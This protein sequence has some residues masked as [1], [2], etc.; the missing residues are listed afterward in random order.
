MAY[1]KII[2][3]INAETEISANVIKLA[4][5]YSYG[6]A[7]EL[8]IYN[9]SKDE[10]TREEF[11]SMA[12]E[13]S[14]EIDI[15]FSIGCYVERLEDIKKAIYTGARAVIIRYSIFENKNLLKE[16][17][18]RFGSEKIMVELDMIDCIGE[19]GE[20]MCNFIEEALV[21]TILLKHVIVSE[22]SKKRIENGRCP[23]IIRDSLVR[24]DIRTLL[25][26][27][28][29]IGLSTNFF[30]NKDI[31]KAKYALKE[32]NIEVNTFESLL[33]FSE[34]K[35]NA[36][37]LIPVVV[38][39]YRTDEVL[40]LAYMNE[41]AYNKTIVS[42]RMTYYSRSRDTLWLKGE[43]SGHYQY[44]KEL[45][46]DCDKDTIL[47]K[48]L[49]IGPAC[50]TGSHN[51]FIHDLVKKEYNH[52]DPFHV[53][54]DVYEVIMDRKRNP[55]EGSYT[56]YLFEKGIDKILKKCGEEAAEIIIAA[57]N[58]NAE[59]LRYEIADF[60]YHMMVL[61]AECGLDWNDITTELAHRK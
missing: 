17:T 16:A 2:P 36:D 32:E 55:K 46:L 5:S 48:V 14:K 33:S 60:L 31:M 21:G 18:G 45:S 11:L 23:V 8:L 47:A 13:I 25:T 34:F 58:P 51:C 28:N 49:Q 42:G 22:H 26:I 43:T 10:K 15:P 24:N 54:K 59:E 57:K 29:V 30:E 35:L 38:Q 40:M 53:F 41:E 61:M 9:Y 44:V 37:G 52:S 20:R 3:Y 6:G 39:D 1:K 4:K 7:D 56:N 19:E 50:H 12:K 27:N